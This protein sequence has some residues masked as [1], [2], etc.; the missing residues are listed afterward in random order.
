MTVTFRLLLERHIFIPQTT[1]LLPT[2]IGLKL[3]PPLIVFPTIQCFN[4][5]LWGGVSVHSSNYVVTSLSLCS[6]VDE[7][8]DHNTDCDISSLE[9]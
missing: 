1:A 2:I 4:I 8:G 5:E 3:L 7:S 9:E 6:L